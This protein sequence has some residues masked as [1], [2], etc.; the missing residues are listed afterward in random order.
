[1]SCFHTGDDVHT[2]PDRSLSRRASD[3]KGTYFRWQQQETSAAP[4]D[5]LAIPV[6]PTRIDL[7]WIDTDHWETGF[8]IERTDGVSVWATLA[9]V[10]AGVTSY[11][12]NGL[13]EG[14][15]WYY[16]VYATNGH[17]ASG[18]SP[19]RSATTQENPDL[20]D[21]PKDHLAVAMQKDGSNLHAGSYYTYE[22]DGIGNRT[23]YVG[24][25]NYGGA[26]TYT[27][28]K[29][30]QLTARDNPGVIH[31]SGYAPADHTV[32]VNDRPTVRDGEYYLGV[33]DV[34]NSSGPVSET[35][36]VKVVEHTS[37]GD[38]PSETCFMAVVPKATEDDTDIAYDSR[39]NLLSD[40]VHTFKWDLKNRLEWVQTNAAIADDAKVRVEFDYDAFDRR[41]EKRVYTWDQVEEDW[42]SE[43]DETIKFV[44]DGWLLV[45]ELDASDDLVRSYIWGMELLAVVDHTGTSP[46]TYWVASDHSGNVR[47][48]VESSDQ[49]VA[50]AYDYSPFGKL[51]TVN[52]TEFAK[53][54][55]FRFS[56]M[57]YDSEVELY[58]GGSRYYSPDTGRWISRE[59]TGESYVANLY[60]YAR[61][62]PVN[63]K[64]WEEIRKELVV[65]KNK[66]CVSCHNPHVASGGS[67]LDLP[68]E[69]QLGAMAW[70]GGSSRAVDQ[71]NGRLYR[72]TWAI[73]FA[74]TELPGKPRDAMY[75]LSE[76]LSEK[77]QQMGYQSVENDSGWLEFGGHTLAAASGLAE[78]GGNFVGIV[79]LP[80]N[81]ENAARNY[82]FYDSQG[83]SFYDATM[84]QFNPAAGMFEGYD[85]TSY[86][87]GD[88]GAELSGGESALRF[89]TS[90]L[91][92]G[93][94]ALGGVQGLRYVGG[95]TVGFIPHRQTGGG[96]FTGS[97][98]DAYDAIRLSTTD[99][100][101]IAR[102]TGIKKRN[103]QKVKDH[104]FYEEHLLD[105]YV[106]LGDPAVMARFDSDLSQ[107][108]AWKRLEEGSHTPA[109]M[110]FL[111][112]EAAESHLMRRWNDPSYNRAH[113]RAQR[114]YPMSILSD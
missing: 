102:H 26:T 111:R 95:G 24:R 33:V 3:P 5:L 35:V 45:A 46:K 110:Q 84:L 64:T 37:Q 67:I 103:I 47:S 48:L 73:S 99:V 108:N 15:T 42:K 39:G 7:A 74:A 55:P 71:F 106:D 98:D 77:S 114:T 28:N 9:S 107:A 50:A 76:R 91:A 29:L 4:T 96:Y 6:S 113:N 104:V 100:E 80:T 79:D 16:R 20:V 82:A 88:F 62:N 18:V 51:V 86:Q 40:S 81:V 38:I 89:G 17:G 27:H 10:A 30:N 19:E 58:Y 34:D 44:W 21:P 66:R 61:N 112:H 31:V 83:L 32:L 36:V 41:T 2:K 90:A 1:M 13:D 87:A 72:T 59:P 43:P 75:R 49:S 57:Y 105:R 22:Y 54:N 63:R 23:A 94:T 56:T 85:R 25:S 53:Q 70:V 12:D 97:A 52:G 93:A 60:A 69:Y 101:N 11:S 8:T 109:D 65:S 14:E 78:G 92:T 68:R